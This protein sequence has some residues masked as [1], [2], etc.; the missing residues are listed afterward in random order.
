M[1]KILYK[2]LIPYMHNI[3]PAFFLIIG[4]QRLQPKGSI[5]VFCEHS[6]EPFKGGSSEVILFLTIATAFVGHVSPLN[7]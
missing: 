3:C 4:I 5:A 1:T 7:Q 6:D 2:F